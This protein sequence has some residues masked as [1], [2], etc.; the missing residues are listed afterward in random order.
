MLKH[1]IPIRKKLH[2]VREEEEEETEDSKVYP[3]Y[4]KKEKVS[5]NED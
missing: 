3:I 1:F 5:A 4:P 2:I